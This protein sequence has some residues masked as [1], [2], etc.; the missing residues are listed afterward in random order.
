MA[1]VNIGLTEGIQ[2]RTESQRNIREHHSLK[3]D[4]EELVAYFV[5]IDFAVYVPTVF[6]PNNDGLNDA[7]APVGTSFVV[8]TYHLI[9]INRW[10]KVFESFDPKEPDC[11]HQGGDHFVRDGQYM[12]RL[13][14][15]SCTRWC[16]GAIQAA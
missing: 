1:P 14:V 7:S 5:P 3:Q 13:E 4:E 8:E 6:S 11:Q 16:R 2:R 10:G 12:Y 9:V 15:Q